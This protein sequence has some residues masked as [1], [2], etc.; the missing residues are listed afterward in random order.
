MII[1]Q[2]RSQQLLRTLLRWL[3]FG[4]DRIS[5]RTVERIVRQNISQDTDM[6]KIAEELSALGEAIQFVKSRD[7]ILR[8]AD[9]RQ[10]IAEIE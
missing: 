1:N 7:C 4:S 9:G 6:P 10:A 8:T 3:C 5:Y 2:E